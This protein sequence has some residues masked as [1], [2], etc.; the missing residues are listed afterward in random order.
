MAIY[1]VKKGKNPAKYTSRKPSQKTGR[2]I[3]KLKGIPYWA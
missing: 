1:S 2:R 3:R